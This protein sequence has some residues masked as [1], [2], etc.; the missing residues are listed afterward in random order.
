MVVHGA[1]LARP[2]F[3]KLLDLTSN[4]RTAHY[5]CL[6]E[7]IK[8][9][10][11]KCCPLLK[12]VYNAGLGVDVEFFRS[13]GVRQEERL[14]VSAGLASRD[15]RTLIAAVRD[16]DAR[17][18]IAADSAWYRAPLD[19]P[20]MI[21]PNVQISSCQNYANLRDLYDRA[22]VV[23]VPLHNSSRAA[24]YAVIGEAMSMSKSV[25]ATRTDASSDLLLEG[26]TGLYVEPQ[27]VNDLREKLILLLGDP[28]LA[29][30]FG[31]AGR[32]RVEDLYSL[33]HYC[34]RI[35]GTIANS[36]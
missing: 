32:R 21:P 1:Y 4:Y 20:S 26:Q 29:R 31:S 30:R 34:T 17:L 23:V 22:S 15:Y 33:D 5:L 19:L 3:G 36:L 11:L 27:D 25:I 10:L 2:T 9:I 7:R 18:I 13:R 28:N 6:S 8:I 24:G 14:I 12:N 16:L 35:E